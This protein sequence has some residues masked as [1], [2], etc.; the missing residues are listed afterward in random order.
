MTDEDRVLQM[1]VDLI[2]NK[3]V[4][5][6]PYKLGHGRERQQPS[7]GSQSPQY[8]VDKE[9]PQDDEGNSGNVWA[10]E[11]TTPSRTTTQWL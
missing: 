11:E 1:N 3:S 5:L 10:G 4:L 8:E 9:W 7:S 6:S 2:G